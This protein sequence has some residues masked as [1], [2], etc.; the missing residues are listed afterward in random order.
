[1]TRGV[2]PIKNMWLCM[3]CLEVTYMAKGEYCEIRRV[4]EITRA[5]VLGLEASK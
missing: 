4:R 2:C 3:D 1:M 5:R